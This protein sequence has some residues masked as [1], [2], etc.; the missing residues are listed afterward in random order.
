MLAKHFEGAQP[1]FLPFAN[2]KEMLLHY[3][4]HAY[5]VARSIRG[6]SYISHLD[7][8]ARRLGIYR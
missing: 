2:G 1:V 4:P 6:R 3:P 8:H 7:F 5:T